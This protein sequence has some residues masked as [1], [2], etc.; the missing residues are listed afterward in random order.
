[1]ETLGICIKQPK[2]C[3]KFIGG[4]TN[5]GIC[6]KNIDAWTNN[7]N[8]V[9]YISELDLADYANKRIKYTDLW[10]KKKWLK[11]VKDYIINNYDDEV[12]ISQC[13]EFIELIAYDCLCEVDWQDLSTILEEFDYNDNWIL[14]GWEEFK[15]KH[16]L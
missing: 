11:Y 1:M 3:Y 6:Y 16:N 10:T 8:E 7:T 2:G 4:I 13:D 9:I 5:N 14:D 15:L 12:E